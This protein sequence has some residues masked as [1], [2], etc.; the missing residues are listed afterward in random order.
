MLTR[1]A[2]LKAFAG[3]GLTT[4]GFTGYALGVEPWHHRIVRYRPRLPNWPDALKLRIALVADIHACEPWMDVERIEEIVADTNKLKPDLVLLLGDY[5]AHH[6]FVRR[7]VP[8]A[9]WA[10]V[11]G[12]LSAPLGV[13]AILGNHDWWDDP[14]AM[15]RGRGPVR[16]RRAL[17]AAGIPV[18]ENDAKRLRKDGRAFWLAGLGDQLALRVREGSWTRRRTR[19]RGVDDLP[20]TMAQISDDAPILLMA[21]EPDIFPRVPKRVALTVA[22]HTHGGQVA[23]AGFTPVVPSRF[24]SRFVRGHIVEEGRHM[25]VSAGLGCSG[26]PIRFGVPPEIVLVELGGGHA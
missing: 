6:R 12:R 4:F 25:I 3:F 2:L 22:G 26:A 13:H 15:M 10:G 24:G 17:E 14:D 18:Y 1:R 8:L 7:P 5:M 20:G 23:L 19:I 21:H 16:A 11:L 9:E